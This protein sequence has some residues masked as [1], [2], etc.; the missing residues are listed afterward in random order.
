MS[1]STTWP[2]W[3]AT[4]EKFDIPAKA[5]LAEIDIRALKTCAVPQP[6]V[7]ALPKFPAV[8]RDLALVVDEEV[9]AGLLMAAIEKA[10][11]KLCEGVKLFDV[12]RGER[13][14]EGKKSLAFS[15]YFRSPDHTLTEAEINTAMDKVLAAAG[16]SFGAVIR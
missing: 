16:K 2:A 6:V 3:Y 13:L 9:G 8:S 4:A 10:A 11:G 12:Y 5:Y 15:I 1:F 7:K 14:G